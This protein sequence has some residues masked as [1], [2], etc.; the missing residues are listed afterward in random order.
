MNILD[1][2]V[3]DGSY[4]IDFKFSCKDVRDL[5]SRAERIGLKYIEVGHG[6]GLNASS[7]EHGIALQT[8]VEYM[9]AAKEVVKEAKLG[10]FCIPGIARLED[11][12]T[13]KENGIDFLRM[14][15]NA[16]EYPKV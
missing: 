10:F 8:D 1:A 12:T 7:H 5:V 2:T 15:V 9:R 6:Q 4:A 13:A 14:G 16:Q 11:I 3:R